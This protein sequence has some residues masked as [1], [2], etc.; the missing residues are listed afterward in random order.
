MDLQQG[1]TSQVQN[2][3]EQ[4]EKAILVCRETGGSL[5]SRL[6]SVLRST[7]EEKSNEKPR[8]ELVPLA[9]SLYDLTLLVDKITTQ[10]K[11]IVERMEL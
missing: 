8:Q 7:D 10:L 6:V 11:S 1:K 4:L 9:A 5:E 2:K 3:L